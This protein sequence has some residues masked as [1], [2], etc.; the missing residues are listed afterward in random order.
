MDAEAGKKFTYFAVPRIYRMDSNGRAV[1]YVKYVTL[2][3]IA[4]GFLVGC[5]VSAYPDRL[6]SVEA[7]WPLLPVG[8]FSLLMLDVHLTQLVIANDRI[9]YR[10]LLATRTLWHKDI[11]G[12]WNGPI[13]KKFVVSKRRR[14]ASIPVDKARFEEDDYFR[15]WLASLPNADPV[16][17]GEGYETRE[18]E[19]EE[20]I[21]YSSEYFPRTYKVEQGSLLLMIPVVGALLEIGLRWVLEGIS[22]S[23][24]FFFTRQG[25][26]GWGCLVAGCLLIYLALK[27]KLVLY[28][29][30]MVLKSLFRTV[31]IMRDEMVRGETYG[32]GFPLFWT[33]EGGRNGKR[34]Q[35]HADGDAYFRGWMQDIPKG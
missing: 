29:D 24:H 31:T 17:S 35:F 15:Q 12:V 6:L 8:A 23:Y 18:F 27:P 4:L 5:I 28:P 11:A 10:R 9:V 25:L 2:L 21:P 32:M 16:G 3:V 26:Y 1:Y 14:G 22:P 19:P 13:G 30:K 20:I 7:L 34:I 33:K